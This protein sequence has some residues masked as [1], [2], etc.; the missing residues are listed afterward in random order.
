MPV[1]DLKT[2]KHII[3]YWQTPYLRT[4]KERVQALI[5]KLNAA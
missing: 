1:L 2:D 5:Q 3:D 4:V